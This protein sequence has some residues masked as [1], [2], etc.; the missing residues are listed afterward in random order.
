MISQAQHFL[1]AIFLQLERISHII[2]VAKT[3]SAARRSATINRNMEFTP[4]KHTH[5]QINHVV[6]KCSPEEMKC[7]PNLW[8]NKENPQL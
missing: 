2:S 3:K 6:D 8:M 4:Q 1:E 5:T 7:L